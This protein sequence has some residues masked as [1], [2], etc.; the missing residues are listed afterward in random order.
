M[1]FERLTVRAT[2]AAERARDAKADALAERIGASLPR[3][4]AATRV[5]DGV[6]LTGRALRRWFALEPALRWLVESLR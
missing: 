5:G 2:T 1:M 6:Q 3:G 4:I